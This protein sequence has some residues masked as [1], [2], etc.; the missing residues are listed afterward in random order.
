MAV[1]KGGQ[2]SASRYT[3]RIGTPHSLRNGVDRI[4]L[5]SIEARTGT[6]CADQHIKVVEHGGNVVGT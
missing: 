1:S 2:E 4:L 6:K 5:E 3:Q